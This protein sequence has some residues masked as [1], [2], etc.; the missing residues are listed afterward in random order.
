[1]I[2]VIKQILK[3]IKYFKN[4]YSKKFLVVSLGSGCDLKLFFINKYFNYYPT[5]FFDYL[6][7]FDKGLEYVENIISNDFLGF[8]STSDFNLKTHKKFDPN[9]ISDLPPDKISLQDKNLGAKHYVPIKYQELNFM[10]YED[11]N[12]LLNSFSKKIYRFRKILKRKN[13]Y[14]IYYRQFDEPI[15]SQYTNELDYEV[16]KK[17][18]FWI[19][20]SKN[21]MEF[22]RNKNIDA[23]ML[24]LFA[25]PFN[26]KKEKLNKYELDK[27]SSEFLNFEFIHYKLAEQNDR[28][29]VEK[30]MSRLFNKYFQ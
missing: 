18:D 16:D 10:H 14:F 20:E 21:F 22:L 19:N 24:T 2:S 30:E 12:Y 8:E 5:E 4:F 28:F 26:F 25:L 3:K 9:L 17:I 15:L 13:I 27:L 23:K 1:M 7:N 6:W 11:I 29:Y